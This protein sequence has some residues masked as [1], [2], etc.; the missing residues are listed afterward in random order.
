MR[1][2]PEE[3]FESNIYPINFLVDLFLYKRY[4]VSLPLSYPIILPTFHPTRCLSPSVVSPFPAKCSLSLS[5]SHS[6]SLLQITLRVA[7]EQTVSCKKVE[8]CL[9]AM[10][11]R[12]CC[13]PCCPSSLAVFSSVADRPHI[14]EICGEDAR[15]QM[16]TSRTN[17]Q[18]DRH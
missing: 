10:T 2:D 17:E 18:T 11:N 4:S 1:F 14:R 6:L 7:N 9:L 12:C 16:P 8:G 15:T 3:I 13:L 5:L